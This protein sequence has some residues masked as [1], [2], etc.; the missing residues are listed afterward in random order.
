MTKAFWICNLLTVLVV[1]TAPAAAQETPPPPVEFLQPGEPDAPPAL[2]KREAKYLLDNELSGRTLE[3]WDSLP[4]PPES[5]GTWL[6]RGWWYANV[7]GIAMVR[8]WDHNHRQIAFDTTSQFGVF[9]RRLG[10]GRTSP[11]EGSARLTLGRFLFRDLDNRDH[12]FEFSVFGG[13]EFLQT[14]RVETVNPNSLF[15]PPS[16]DLNNPVS[17]DGASSSDIEYASRLNSFE[18]NYKVQSRLDCDRMELQ[19]NGCWVRRASHGFT[20]HGIAGVRYVDLSEGVQWNAQ[21]IL[22]VNNN[23]LVFDGTDDGAYVVESSNDM[24]GAQAGGGLSYETD[25][26]SLTG[27]GRGG[28][29]YNDAQARAALRY[30]DGATGDAIDGVGFV[31][32]DRKGSL[33]I[34]IQAG[35]TA[36][37]HLRPNVSLK[38]GYELFYL[39]AVALAPNELNFEPD[40]NKVVVTGNPFYHGISLGAEFYW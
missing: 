29:F 11:A 39:T 40:D 21:D 3:L 25:R 33:P 37:Y 1:L 22:L 8:R 34:V 10:L 20:Y 14:C 24:F 28:V 15:V 13:N 5:S 27:W 12:T 32:S 19:P 31:T 16:V 18:W 38:A 4:A 35:L 6:R 23:T 17:F 30:T 26:W 7:D 2:Q 36:R 9:A